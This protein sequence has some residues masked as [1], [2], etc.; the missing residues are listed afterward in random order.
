MIAFTQQFFRWYNDTHCHS[1]IDFMAPEAI[2]YGRATNDLPEAR[3]HPRRRLLGQSKSLQGQIL[4]PPKLQTTVW[5]NP[6]K[7]EAAAN[8]TLDPS[9]LINASW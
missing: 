9:T 6:P 3:P 5:I 2:H 4:Q 7:Q 8:T 1:G